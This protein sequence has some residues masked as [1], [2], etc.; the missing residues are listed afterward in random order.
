MSSVK[1]TEE[2][3]ELFLCFVGF[4]DKQRRVVGFA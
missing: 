1:E 3:I 4:N 2:T